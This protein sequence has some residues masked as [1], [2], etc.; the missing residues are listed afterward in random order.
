M[1]EHA[2]MLC[3]NLGVRHLA[4]VDFLLSDDGHWTLLEV[5]TMPGFT[6]TSLLPRASEAYGVARSPR[7]PPGE[8]YFCFPRM[9]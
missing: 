8:R 4:R 2:L 6:P 1:Q 5:N 7:I 9:S 3:R